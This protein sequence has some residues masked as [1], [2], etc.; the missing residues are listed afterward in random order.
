MLQ[1]PGVRGLPLFAE[2]ESKFFMKAYD[3]E[4]ESV[5]DASG[6]VV[7]AVIYMDQAAVKARRL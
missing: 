4:V 1:T 2:S 3:L 6:N 7:E 5:K